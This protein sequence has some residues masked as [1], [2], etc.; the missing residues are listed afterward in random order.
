MMRM[1]MNNRLIHKV[2]ITKI[3][4]ALACV[5]G[6]PFIRSGRLR[7]GLPVGLT[8]MCFDCEGALAALARPRRAALTPKCPRAF[9]S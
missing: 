3:N 4:G 2:R 9:V 6:N 7:A 8:D 1:R 5:S